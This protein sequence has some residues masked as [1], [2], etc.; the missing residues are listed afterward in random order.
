MKQKHISIK[1]KNFAAD[2]YKPTKEI[3]YDDKKNQLLLECLRQYPVHYGN[4]LRATSITAK[5]KKYQGLY[6]YVLR[7]TEHMPEDQFNTCQRI[8]WVLQKW[9]DFPVCETPGCETRLIVDKTSRGFRIKLDTQGNLIYNWPRHCCS[10]CAQNNPVTKQKIIQTVQDLYGSQYINVY[11]VPSIIEKCKQAHLENLGVDIPAKSPIILKKM[12]DTCI[13]RYGYPNILQTPQAIAAGHTP[14][15]EARRQAT[16]T[17][18]MMEEYGVPWFVM[19]DEFKAKCNLSNGSSKEER[20]IVDFV[21]SIEPEIEINTFKV[22]PPLQLDIYVP[23]CKVA[24][25]FNGTYFHSIEKRP[26][27]MDYHLKK[28]KMC[29]DRGIKLVHIWETDYYEWEKLTKLIQDVL[30]ET[31]NLATGE[32]IV[33]LD[34]SK[35]NKCWKLEGYDLI[36][37]TAPKLIVREKRHAQDRYHVPDCGELVYKRKIS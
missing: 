27:I 34:R 31:V 8:F 19:T 22:I 23:R 25:E 14:E 9:Q 26:D 3:I 33:R 15:V 36:E 37:E 16:L 21:R 28:T 18:T 5:N 29:E 11:Q 20:A 24:F 10:I 1:A 6:E 2:A 4:I 30:A 32:N 7:C 12:Q 17:S 13:E 35:F